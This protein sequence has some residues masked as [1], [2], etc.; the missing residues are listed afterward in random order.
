[1]RTESEIRAK[2]DKFM[3]KLNSIKEHNPDFNIAEK[4]EIYGIIDALLWVIG[5]ESGKRI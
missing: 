1:M 4:G 2:I 3:N 5:D